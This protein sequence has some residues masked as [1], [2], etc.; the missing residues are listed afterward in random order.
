MWHRRPT[1]QSTSHSIVHTKIW[2]TKATG[3]RPTVDFSSPPPSWEAPWQSTW[4]AFTKPALGCLRAASCGRHGNC[5]DGL[6]ELMFLS[7]LMSDRKTELVAACKQFIYP[8]F[9]QEKSKEIVNG[10]AIHEEKSLYNVYGGNNDCGSN[11]VLFYSLDTELTSMHVCSCRLPARFRCLRVTSEWSYLWDGTLQCRI[12]HL[13]PQGFFK[14]IVLQKRQFCHHLIT[15]MS[16][17]CSF[18]ES[19]RGSVLF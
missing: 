15:F 5:F 14:G 1:F 13:E 19:Q 2:P 8:P 18:N 12:N 3:K 4:A 6:R 16:S 11:L 7:D 10:G 17:F 9:C